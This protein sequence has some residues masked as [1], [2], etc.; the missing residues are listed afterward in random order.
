M[1]IKVD[2]NTGAAATQPLGWNRPSASL[3]E[4][5]AAAHDG[6]PF[7]AQDLLCLSLGVV[8][9]RTDWVKPY[10]HHPVA[11]RAATMSLPLVCQSEVVMRVGI[12]RDER[13]GPLIR[14]DRIGQPLQLVQ[15]V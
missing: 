4:A 15:N 8:C 3:H 13:N 6:K 9:P 11:Q 5:T 2:E 14:R 1:E 10:I 12:L 7:M